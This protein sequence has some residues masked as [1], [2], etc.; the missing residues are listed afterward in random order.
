MHGQFPTIIPLAK[1]TLG[2][3]EAK[4][5]TIML[6]ILMK[7]KRRG[8]AFMPGAW[9]AGSQTSLPETLLREAHSAS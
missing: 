2:G 8:V 4:G 1:Q 9:T 6:N 3:A 5:H 7:V